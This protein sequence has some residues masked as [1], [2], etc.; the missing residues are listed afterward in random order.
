M[1]SDLGLGQKQPSEGREDPAPIIWPWED[2]D[3][4][5]LVTEEVSDDQVDDNMADEDAP[6]PG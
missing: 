6:F 3:D 2:P 5:T 1:P 4:Q